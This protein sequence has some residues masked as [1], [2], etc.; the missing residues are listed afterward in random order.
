M[1][2]FFY[3]HRQVKEIITIIIPKTFANRKRFITFVATI[4]VETKHNINL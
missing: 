2:S 4:K 3:F 1:T